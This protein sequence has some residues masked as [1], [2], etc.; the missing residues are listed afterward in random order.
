MN[1]CKNNLTLNYASL[2]Y[3]GFE[4]RAIFKISE[5]ITMHLDDLDKKGNQL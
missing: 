1:Y 4:R 5:S 3:F 2:F